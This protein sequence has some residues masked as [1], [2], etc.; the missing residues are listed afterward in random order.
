MQCFLFD[1]IDT[2]QVVIIRYEDLIYKR[3]RIKKIYKL[4]KL[5]SIE[6]SKKFFLPKNNDI[7][8]IL[9]LIVFKIQKIYQFSKFCQ[10]FYFCNLLLSLFSKI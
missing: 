1:K 5:N 3:P 6:N 7:H 10:K 4:L 2:K 8:K 9:N